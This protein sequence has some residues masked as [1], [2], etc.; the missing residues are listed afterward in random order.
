MANS[1]SVDIGFKSVK[2]DIS[3]VLGSVKELNLGVKDVV[4]GMKGLNSETKELNKNVSESNLS[5]KLINLRA[6]SESLKDLVGSFKSLYSEI[7]GYFSTIFHFADSYA[8]KGDKI[9]KTSRMLGL[10]V[11]DYQ[12]FSSAAVDAGMSVEEMDSALKKFSVNLAK[13][14][15]GDKTMLHNFSKAIFGTGG[16][17]NALNSLKTT[18]DVLIALADGFSKYS[19]AEKK[20]FVASE[21]FGKSG[22]KMSEILSQG[23][24]SLKEFLDS[25]NRGFSEEGAIKAEAFTH[26][27]Q[28]LL[29][30][31]EKIKIEV[32]Q[33]LFPAFK[34]MFGEILSM[35]RGESGSELK[36][37]LKDAAFAFKK[38]VLDMLPRIPAILENIVRIVDALTP[39]VVTAG[40][41]IL[42]ILPKVVSLGISLWA[43]KPLVFGILGY[44]VKIGGVVVG[45]PTLVWSL[46]TGFKI[47]AM[48]VGGAFY[49]SLGLVFVLLGEIA[50]IVYQIYKNWDMLRTLTFDEFFKAIKMWVTEI[51]DWFGEKF[52]WIGEGIRDFVMGGLNTIDEYVQKIRGFLSGIFSGLPDK[53]QSFFGLNEPIKVEESLGSA[54]SSLGSSVARAVMESNTTT[55]NRFSVDFKNMPRGVQ[56]TAPDHGDFDYSRGYVLA[57]M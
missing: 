53:I 2:N 7:S 55:T 18:N 50:F 22:L 47:A 9:A 4:L 12:A 25:Y 16:D 10:S 52:R 1:I 42:S 39:E 6:Y 23:G 29:E 46:V 19:T 14:R 24:Q 20:A 40:V 21:L 34:E 26:E 51:A 11:K 33:E 17:L 48:V 37:V 30:E 54:Q 32:A 41:V 45:L 38:F 56:V 15:G 43:M 8:E 44:I 27:L 28:M 35:L 5:K 13:A 36:K 3:Q 49:A 31:F 57:G